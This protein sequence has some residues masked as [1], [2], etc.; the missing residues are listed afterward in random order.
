LALISRSVPL[1]GEW[2]RKGDL[3]RRVAAQPG[4]LITRC[5]EQLM[6]NDEWYRSWDY[7]TICR[8]LGTDDYLLSAIRLSTEPTFQ[9][10]LLHRP[11]GE[12]RFL[13][14]ERRLMRRFHVEFSRHYGRAIVR[15]SAAPFPELSPR[16]RQ[17]LRCLM[18]GDSVKQAAAR[19]GLSRHTVHDYVVDLYRRTGVCTR[20][21]LLALCL[22][23]HLTPDSVAPPLGHGS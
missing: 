12:R 11:T 15:P 23:L 2:H 20:G 21:E 8:P 4:P 6:G 16:L 5:R 13:P 3:F 9:H 22:R 1:E 18:E 10:F 19:M 14:R 7:E 17:T